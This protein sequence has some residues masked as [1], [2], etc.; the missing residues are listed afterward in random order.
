MLLVGGMKLQSFLAVVVTCA[1]PSSLFFSPRPYLWLL[2]SASFY[3]PC[4]TFPNYA[5]ISILFHKCHCALN[6]LFNLEI[7]FSIFKNL[8]GK[9][10]TKN[11]NSVSCEKGLWKVRKAEK[12]MCYRQTN[13]WSTQY[14]VF[15]LLFT[16]DC[17]ISHFFFI[18]IFMDTWMNFVKFKWRVNLIF[19]TIN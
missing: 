17:S 6:L 10:T 1:A 14:T 19:P 15:W 3:F 12:T 7:V 4:D 8:A 2:S 16:Q 11:N 5:S 13:H 18:F 9:K